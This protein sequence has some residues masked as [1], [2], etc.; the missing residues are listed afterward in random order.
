MFNLIQ[1]HFDFDSLN[2]SISDSHRN[3]TRG[4]E[5]TILDLNL[6][7][8]QNCCI[9][10]VITSNVLIE[11][12]DQLL[13][14]ESI[15]LSIIDMTFTVATPLCRFMANLSFPIDKELLSY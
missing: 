3:S 8:Y 15:Q 14:R 13:N 6:D 5:Q 1:H 10:E 2:F 7:M 12:L 4:N 11:V 9:M